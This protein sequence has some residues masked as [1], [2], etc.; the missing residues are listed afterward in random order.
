MACVAPSRV[1]W[2]T[3]CLLAGT[4]LLAACGGAVGPAPITVLAASSVAVAVEDVGTALGLDLTVVSAGSQVIIAQ[5]EAGAPA[6]LVLL[7]DP[8]AAQRLHA[9]GLLG[10]PVALLAS[11]LVVVAPDSPSAQSRPAFALTDLANPDARVVLADAGVPLGHLTRLALAE[12]EQ[13][14]GPLGF[15]QA[16][17]DHADSLEGSARAVLAKVAAGEADLGVVYAANA[18]EAVARGEVVIVASLADTGVVSTVV[19]QAATPAGQAV[20]D[21]MVSPAARRVLTAHGFTILLP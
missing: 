10:A 13:R 8:V 14:D 15:M 19:G 20:L 18:T 2:R 4:A 12:V 16:V 17:V 1:T 3:R 6:D 5:V 9:A 21:A 11:P 7:A